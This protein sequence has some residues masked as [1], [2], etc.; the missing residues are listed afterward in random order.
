M[1]V[2]IY[3]GELGLFIS[4][5]TLVPKG[6]GTYRVIVYKTFGACYWLG[7]VEAKVLKLMP[8]YT[9][10]CSDV[11]CTGEYRNTEHVQDAE[12]SVRFLAPCSSCTRWVPRS[13]VLRFIR[14]TKYT[15][16]NNNSE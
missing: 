9:H 15:H 12:K 3:A 14:E 10:A 5:E 11:C 8:H 13:L 1:K 4:D 16:A 6:R 7:T 2:S